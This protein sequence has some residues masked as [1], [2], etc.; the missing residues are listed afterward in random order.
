MILFGL[1]FCVP[2][3][4]QA[5]D[6]KPLAPEFNPI[7]WSKADCIAARK[8]F[9]VGDGANIS[10]VELAK[11]WLSNQAPCFGEAWGKCLP[12]GITKTSISFGGKTEFANIGD[13]IVEVYNYALRIAAILAVIMI[14]VAG[15]QYVTSGG[16]S[17]MISSAKK[18][19]TGALI[20]LFIAYT[21]YF[22]LNTINP[23]LVELRLPQ[24][25]LIRP[26][27]LS[28]EFCSDLNSATKLALATGVTNLSSQTEQKA[29]YSAVTDFT[30]TPAKNDPALDCGKKFFLQNGGGAT[31]SGDYCK[32]EELCYVAP[33][34][35][36]PVVNG[37]VQ[38]EKKYDCIE[39]K[40]VG[41]IYSS[42]F[43]GSGDWTG[44]ALGIAPSAFTGKSGEGWEMSWSECAAGCEHDGIGT[45]C[46]D[47]KSSVRGDV[48]LQD[49]NDKEASY[50]ILRGSNFS[51]D[52][53][54]ASIADCEKDH[55][56]L[57]GF[58]I[59]LYFNE[60]CH[61][62]DEVHVIGRNGVDLG[63]MGRGGLTG[64]FDGIFYAG[65]TAAPQAAKLKPEYFFTKE[66]IMKGFRL[67]INVNYVHDIDTDED[68]KVYDKL[69]Q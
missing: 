11:G 31:C 45:I 64:L 60:N 23:A 30:I 27:V 62:D 54:N 44:C 2:V 69:M 10:D 28:S 65:L 1:L 39:A 43:F 67:D 47:G 46:N 12:A 17:E 34:A 51:D 4:A 19:I 50:K 63:Y 33:S 59:F 8:G 15:V 22:I 48:E 56:G 61:V 14:I 13:Y 57:K 25:Y 29:A 40:V 7:C 9:L 58:A 49:L 52:N 3:M 32:A 37:A 21:S 41:K 6:V 26:Q 66:E 53:I 35:S 16:N 36:N 42:S 20:G 5:A 18:R 68:E 55:G 38:E 24:I